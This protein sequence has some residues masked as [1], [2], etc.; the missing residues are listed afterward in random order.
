MIIALDQAIPHWKIAFS[1]LGEIH[2]F[3]GADLKPEDIRDADALIVRSITPVNAQLLDRSA[4]RFIAAASAGIDH[5]DRDYLRKREI[6]FGYAAGCNANAVSEHVLT[7][8]HIVASRRGW[9]LHNKSLAVIG[10]GHVGSRVA[11][12]AQAAGMQ[13]LLCDPPLRDQTGDARYRSFEEALEA[14]ILTFHVPLTREGRYPTWRLLNRNVL[15]RLGPK[16][17]LINSSRGAVFDNR[18]LRA[19]LLEKS[20]EGAILDVWE[21]EPKIDFSLLELVDIGTPHLAGTSMDGKI[22]ATEMV[23]DE[24]C[25]FAGMK[26][27]AGMEDLYP[28]PRLIRIENEVAAQ[29]AILAALEQALDIEQDDSNLRALASQPRESAAEGFERLRTSHVLRPE[30]HHFNI[31]L[32]GKDRNL[33]ELLIGM[34]FKVTNVNDPNL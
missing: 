26:A 17:F 28:K 24:F 4:V 22:R 13:V 8:L 23:R 32:K 7:A 30:F 15:K 18:E 9:E 3:S 11:N 16:Q 34:G 12:K 1:G 10:V 14:D 25:R 29:K 6:S 33:S 19:A 20:I 5:I 31:Q 2:P 27:S 21:N